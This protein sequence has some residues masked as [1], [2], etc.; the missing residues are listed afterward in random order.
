MSMISRIEWF[1]V[2][3]HFRKYMKIHFFHQVLFSNESTFTNH[4]EVNRHNMHYWSVNK[5]HWIRQVECQRPW[6]V[7]VWW[8]EINWI[9]NS[10]VGRRQ[11]MNW[12]A[13][14]PDLTPPD[15]NLWGFLKSKVDDEVP[16]SS[17]NMRQRIKD[18]CTQVRPEIFYIPLIL[19]K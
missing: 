5:P 11:A 6:S 3:G 16:T 8:L 18:T 12:P 19:S 2:N 7:N 10:L 9:N 13:R 14:S 1:S 15:L 4:D 17:E